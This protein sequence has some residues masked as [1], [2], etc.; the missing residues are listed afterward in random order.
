MS[1][2]K[3]KDLNKG[4]DPRFLFV[5][6]ELTLQEI[7]KKLAG[8]R[9]CSLPHLKDRSSSEGWVAQREAHRLKVADRAAKKA[10]RVSSAGRVEPTE[11]PTFPIPPADRT[12]PSEAPAGGPV[13]TLRPVR[14][15]VYQEAVDR[16]ID[17]VA[18]EQS[19]ELLGTVRALGSAHTT[20]I[21]A[22]L[23]AATQASH[24][25]AAHR[26]AVKP[27][28]ETNEDGEDIVELAGEGAG[29]I[30]T[31]RSGG[32]AVE[33]GLADRAQA[34]QMLSQAQAVLLRAA[35]EAPLNLLQR[36]G[37]ALEQV[38]KQV[39]F[40][41]MR[42][43]GTLPPDKV[44]HEFQQQFAGVLAQ[45]EKSLPHEEY[46]KVVTAMEASLVKETM[47]N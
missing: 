1:S 14:R 4:T 35:R 24:Y 40:L 19:E 38:R 12:T 9:G 47:A 23:L 2:G 22:A 18:E 5:T 27:T 45:L 39:E 46:V 42:V 44:Q 20:I 32:L 7:A 37:L 26:V 13:M 43:E 30:K 16:A 17:A 33:M 21:Q 8:Q 10:A 11:N 31:T 36:D 28:G 6:T 29:L 34:L 25:I 15:N 41:T 3:K